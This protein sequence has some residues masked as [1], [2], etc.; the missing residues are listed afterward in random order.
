MS[1]EKKDHNR[2]PTR[3]PPKN[4]GNGTSRVKICKHQN[5]KRISKQKQIAH[6]FKNGVYHFY[7]FRNAFF[8]QKY[9][10]RTMKKVWEGRNTSAD[11]ATYRR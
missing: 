11:N 10:V 2:H 3:I 8:D 4:A 5:K 7:N 9:P 6:P 1:K